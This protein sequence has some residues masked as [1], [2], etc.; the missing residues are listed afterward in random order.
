MFADG[1]NREAASQ[2]CDATIPLLTSLVDKS[3]LRLSPQGRYDFHPLLHQYAAQKLAELPAE[4]HETRAKHSQYFLSLIEASH[5]AG[6]HSY[7][8]DCSEEYQNLLAALAWSQEAGEALTGLRLGNALAPFWLSQSYF[9]EGSHWLATV[10]AHPGA[11]A[12]SEE[13]A[14][15]LIGASRIATRKSDRAL[16]LDY[17][18]EALEIAQTLGLEELRARVFLILGSESEFRGRVEEG[19]NHFQTALALAQKQGHDELA[20]Q[21]LFLLGNLEGKWA[22][23]EQ[24]R[25]LLEESLTLLRKLGLKIQIAHNL[26][27]LGFM[28]WLSGDLKA[29]RAYLEEAVTLAL[30]VPDPYFACTARSNLGGVMQ[31]LGDLHSAQTLARQALEFRY[32]HKDKFGLAYSM[33]NFANLAAVQ[34]NFRRAIR[35]WGVSERLHQEIGS[36]M[37]PL[38]LS[39]H[40]RFVASAR[41]RLDNSVFE[42]GWHEGR[43]M[44]LE[45]AVSYALEAE[46]IGTS[47]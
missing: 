4:R 18:K 21:A 16:A 15:A 27:N 30:A 45:Q 9:G 46:P 12:P 28:L 17:G 6:E 20:A 29:A 36:P 7:T 47:A 40:L 11:R 2:V 41:D 22:N 39:R 44:D 33:E 3:L 32:E 37:P 34:G 13:R 35:L 14:K 38:W 24:S 26:N 43:A 1:L 19:R 25:T 5:K 8:K 31:D 10:L 42:S 23:Y